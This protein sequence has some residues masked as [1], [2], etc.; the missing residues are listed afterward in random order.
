MSITEIKK[1]L[2]KNPDNIKKLLEYYKF[3]G[4]HSTTKEIR[5]ARDKESNKTSI[6]VMINDNLFAEDFAKA[7]KGD[8]FS[9]I[10]NCRN[11]KLYEVINTTKALFNIENGLIG[12]T[13]QKKTVFGGI[14]DNLKKRNEQVYSCETYRE[15]I[16]N[17]YNNGYNIRFLRDGI[18][19]KTQKK[20][21][22]GYCNETNRITVPWRDYEGKI[23]GIMGRYNGTSDN[24]P[25]WFPVIPFSKSMVLFGYSENYIQLLNNDII[26]VGESEKFVLQLDTIG[27]NNAVALGKNSVSSQQIKAIL[28]TLPKKIIMCYDEG[29]DLNIIINQCM[30]IK[31]SSKL[32]NIEVGYVYDEN[33][34]ILN[35]GSKDSPSDL[36]KE[37]F[38]RLVN[39]HVRWL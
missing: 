19:L 21:N 35:E 26:Y 5:C 25:K 11:L 39:Y 23:V 14:F 6:R 13:F 18:S 16:L 10:C 28:K 33:N 12:E 7:I 9:I 15:E 30:K 24:L 37:N 36:G 3:Y 1:E 4:I 31:E 20:F 27:Y 17:D 2:C 32:L 34:E 8:L 29:L 38:E 22:I